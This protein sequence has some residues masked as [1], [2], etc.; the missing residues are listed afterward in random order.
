MKNIK[1]VL[2][3]NPPSYKNFDGGAGSRW[4]ATREAKS[5][6]Y[7][8][9]LAYPTGL[10]EGARLLDA[11]VEGLD[12]TATIEI[13]KG[14]DITVLY[15]SAPSFGNDVSIAKA[16]KSIH[17]SAEVVFVGPH[18][19]VLP[20]ETMGASPYIDFVIRGEFDYSIR[21]LAKGSPY[22]EI[23]GL[24]W[25]ENGKLTINERVPFIENLDQMPWAAKVFKEHVPIDKYY[26]P[27]LLKPYIAIYSARGCP[28]QCTFCLWPQTF[29]GRRHRTRDI[30]DVVREV[31]FIKN[32]LPQVKEIYFDDD[33]F[34][35]NK[36]RL[37]EFCKLVA[38]LGVTWSSTSRANLD[39][40]TLNTMKRSG[41]RLLVVGYES[42]NEAI[43]KNIKKNIS[44]DQMRTFTRS[45][46][47]AGVMLH[48]CFVLGL[49]GETHET[50]EETYR[51]ACE[52]NTDMMQVAVA[53]P[54]PGTELYNYLKEKNFLTNSPLVDNE[55]YQLCNISYPEIGTEE[56]CEAMLDFYRRYYH[57]PRFVMKALFQSFR[58]RAE[59]ARLWHSGIE[60][61]RFLFKIGRKRREGR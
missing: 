34:T 31:E 61:H 30:Q 45:A 16:I 52:L 18:P 54:Y 32:E 3:L 5:F 12:R 37:L 23:Q 1:R 17:P 58:D 56:I 35:I 21:D 36:N 25:R 14:Y 46:K 22:S 28:S 11:P 49:P 48:S 10:L 41:C 15:T 29:A 60:L 43:L 53:A 7:P 51:F 40:D 20:S 27:Y 4:P 8:V 39:Y 9:W 55:G 6:W 19:T 42:G 26:I 44:K 47:R 33:T 50:I 24:C 38:P 13:A 59:A 57:R 2:F